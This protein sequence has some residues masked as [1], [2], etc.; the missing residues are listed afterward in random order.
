[1][2]DDKTLFL[3]GDMLIVQPLSGDTEPEFLKLVD[4]MRDADLAVANLETVIHTFRGHAQV[5]SGGAWLATPPAVA[6]DLKWAGID[7]VATANNHSFDYGSEGVLETLSHLKAAGIAMAG[8]G[9]DLQAARAPGLLRCKLGQVALVSMT[10]TFPYY[11]QA[12]RSRTDIRGRPGVNPLRTVGGFA[13]RCP[14]HRFAEIRKADGAHYR[15]RSGT[16]RWRGVVFEPGE[17]WALAIARR[18]V[19]ADLTANLQ[20]V[21]DAAK[22][23]DFTIVSLHS[24]NERRWLSAVCRQ[25][26]DAGADL[27]FVQGQHAVRGIEIHKG[28]PVFYG[29]GDFVFQ[30]HLVPAVPQEAYEMR[31]LP[32]DADMDDFRAT[33]GVPDRPAFEGVGAVVTVS[34]SGISAIRLLPVDLRFD[35]DDATLGTPKLANRALGRRIISAIAAQSRQFGTQVRYDEAANAGVIDL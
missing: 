5:D 22:T 30:P 32:D 19:L 4:V 2:R 7:M 34:G 15:R 11:G 27:V 8:S 16:V 18:P 23:A 29:L 35:A 31:G 6:E 20:A 28:R 13:I 26:V 17:R 12:S 10:A 24:H 14:E 3:A 25:F 21:G 1:M 33:Y 9:A